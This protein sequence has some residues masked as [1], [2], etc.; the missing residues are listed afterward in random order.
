VALFHLAVKVVSRSTGRSVVA[1]AAYR[2]GA[3]LTDERQ[4]LTPDYS[5]RGDV[6]ETIIL[7]PEN[8]PAWARDR[9]ALWTAVDAAEK[10][11]DAQTAREVEVALPRELTVPQQRDL[12]RTFVQTAFVARG[13]VADVAI[14]EGHR[15]AEPNPHA[16][17]LL[18]TRTLTPD[19]FGPKNRD[20][21]AKDLLVSWRHQ[22]EVDC[23][24]ALAA[25][26]HTARIDARS[27]ADQGLDRRPTVHAV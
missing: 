16:H 3:A 24:K 2:A 14:H 23:N 17:I 12:L 9:Q 1:A 25:Q 4:G 26:G 27:L 7:A 10:R 11:K 8:A 20:W 5:R 6:R 22:W 13:M 21:N 19:G 15:P 18:T